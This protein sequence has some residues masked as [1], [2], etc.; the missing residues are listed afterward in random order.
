MPEDKIVWNEAAPVPKERLLRPRDTLR[1][2]DGG[3]QAWA[4][5]SVSVTRVAGVF[6]RWR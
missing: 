1:G 3:A 5:I 6:A 2:D 4:A